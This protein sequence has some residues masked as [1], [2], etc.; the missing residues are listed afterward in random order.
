M[1][2]VSSLS[3]AVRG[4]AAFLQGRFGATLEPVTVSLLSPEAV[5]RNAETSDTHILN[6]FFYRLSP[7]GFH[8][9]ATA[10]E[11]N[12]IR[13]H[14]LLTPFVGTPE[15][16]HEDIAFR[17]LG[18][19]IRYLSEQP[20]V[21]TILPG[22]SSGVAS[23]FREVPAFTEYQ[24]QAVMQ[25]LTMEELNHIWTTQGGET[26]Y[27][28]SAAYEFALVPIEPLARRTPAAPARAAILDLAPYTHAIGANGMVS[29]GDD[30]HA[31][32]LAGET[33]G[34]PP[35]AG[36]LP[37]ILADDDG[38]LTTQPSVTDDAASLNVAI[39]GLPGA[40]V[41]LE[42]AWNRA[43]GGSDTQAQAFDVGAARIDDP[44]AIVVLPL[45]TIEAGDAALV[46]ASILD[47]TDQPLAGQP[48][49]N[50]ISFTV[51]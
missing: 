33:A 40:R 29:F 14:A 37:V 20:V 46:R 39:A 18:L 7:S 1:E 17:I 19:A 43:S 24:L 49:S 16:P 21:P 26:A 27:R 25:S 13:L 34:T 30:A 8:A 15:D 22:A 4:I 23:D 9:G 35:P 11:P 2:T 28:L 51:S 38:T 32:P 10:E 36:W 12:F 5:R 44:D 45:G 31:V 3:V 41:Q 47:D 50:S 6:L 42:L 48:V